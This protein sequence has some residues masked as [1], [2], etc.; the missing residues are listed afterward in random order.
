ML[1]GSTAP[2][3]LEFAALP[4]HIRG[5]GTSRG[6]TGE[7]KVSLAQTGNNA[8]TGAICGRR[9]SYNLILLERSPGMLSIRDTQGRPPTNESLYDEISRKRLRF[10]STLPYGVLP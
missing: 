8:A 3:V 6:R 9:P 7:G 5:F 1:N 4:E 2:I 10:A